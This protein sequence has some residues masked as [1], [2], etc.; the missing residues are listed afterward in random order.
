MA[1]R[2][3]GAGKLGNG[4]PRVRGRSK[5]EGEGGQ[6][7][8]G[9]GCSVSDHKPPH[10]PPVAPGADA[11]QKVREDVSEEEVLVEESRPVAGTRRGRGARS[12]RRPADPAPYT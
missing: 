2:G 3:G 9:L 1:L 8:Q 12:G 7:G 10:T 5:T 4:R 11:P 6:S